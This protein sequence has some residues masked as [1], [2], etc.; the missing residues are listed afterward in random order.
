MAAFARIWAAETSGR[1]IGLTASTNAA[2]VMAAEAEKAGAPMITRNIAQFLGKI[3]DSDR[4]RGHMEVCPGDVLVVDEASQ[5]STEDMGRIVEVA[6]RC[7]AMVIGVGDT[8]QL[9]AVDAGGIFRLIAARH[10]HWKLSEVRRFR[11]VWEREASLRL[12]RGEVAAL[13]DY[14]ARGRIY[15]G[16]QGRVFDD[17]V[18]LW[19]NDYLAGRDSLLMAT[20]NE[21]AARLAA[22]VR[23]RL[24]GFGLVDPAGAIPLTDGNQA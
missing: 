11:H 18:T 8:E 10:G 14:D 24:I 5:V 1:V 4:T 16:P 13:A 20:S 22:L 21:T 15:D 7:G 23:E 9:E 12:R 17:V 6:R 19:V 2:R 3:K